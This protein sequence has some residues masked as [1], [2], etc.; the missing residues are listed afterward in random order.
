MKTRNKTII[1]PSERVKRGVLIFSFLIS[2]F[3]F[4]WW[5]LPGNRLNNVLFYML[6][7]GEAY[8]LLM[9]WGFWFTIWP[10]K[11]E[12]FVKYQIDFSPSVDIFITV[13]GEPVEVVRKTVRGARD[14][15]YEKHK[16][17]ILN[18]GKVANKENWREIEEMAREEGV[19]CITRTIPGGAKAGNV[20]N[21]LKLTEGEL[22]AVLDADMVPVKIFLRKLVPYFRD[23]GVGFVQS[24]QY[25]KNYAANEISKGSWE[26]QEFF[27]GSIMEGKDKSNAAF[28]C[29]TNFLIR[30]RAFEEVGGLQE[31]NIAEDFVTSMQIH[32]RG[33]KSRY[34][35]E[36]LCKGLAPEDMLAY[37]KQQLRWARGSLESLFVNNPLFMKG[38]SWGQKFQ[39]L[40]SALYYFNGVIVLIDIVMPLLFLFFGLRPVGATST[41]FALFF[42]PFMFL[43]LYTLNLA[44]EGRLTYR[45]MS[46]SQSS[47][48]LQ[49]KA[50]KSIIFKQKMGFSVTPKQ[51]QEGNFLYLAYPHIFYI[52]LTIAGAVVA[53]GREGINSSVATNLA[54]GGFNTFMFLPYI[55]AAY[56]WERLTSRFRDKQLKPSVKKKTKAI[57]FKEGV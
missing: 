28:V 49:L 42:L 41:S 6:L 12:N 48:V 57:Y 30:R 11:K 34:T 36:V 26:Q 54:W 39:Y 35:R 43:N 9:A 7:F 29:G 4:S 22:V 38:L 51:Q 13:C 53:I 56:K 18:D 44:S 45:A 33:W 37:Y 55:K 40:N 52:L 5:F 2:L 1:L 31:D 3:Y 20:N 17:Y 15:L 50:L 19:Y 23:K 47:W 8:H 27:F 25:Y 32:K 21:G 14:Q 46:F 16:V 24:P 10:G